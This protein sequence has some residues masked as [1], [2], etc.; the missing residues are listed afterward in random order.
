[1]SGDPVSEERLRVPPSERFAGKSHL[2]SLSDALAEL[3]RED[4]PSRAGHRQIALLQRSPVTQVLFSFEAGGHLDEH[5]AHGLV[6][7]HVLEGK[8]RVAAEGT[9]HQLTSG[10]VLVLDADVPHDVRAVEKS[11]MLLT[12]HLSPKHE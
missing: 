7:I 8:L 2:F 1:M 11:A 6:T 3:R 4:H 5:S 9:D 10:D 12:V